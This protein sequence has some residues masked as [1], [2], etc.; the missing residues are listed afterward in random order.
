MGLFVQLN[1]SLSMR[2]FLL[3]VLLIPALTGLVHAQSQALSLR[4]HWEPGK[5]YRQ[6]TSTETTSPSPGKEAPDQQLNV[7]Q[8]TLLQV[9]KDTPDHQRQVGVTFASVRGEIRANGKTLTYDS[10]S[11]ETQNPALRQVF[12]Q[13]VGKKF[14]LVYD[15]QDRFVDVR[16]MMSLSSEAGSITSLSAVADANQ[17]ALLF[18]KSLEMGLP[19]LPVHV[20]DTWTMDETMPFPKAGEVRVQ[21]NGKLAAVESY[22][23]RPHARIVFEGKFGNTAA[24]ADKP[25]SLTEITSD[26]SISGVLYFDLESRIVSLTSYTTKIKLQAPGEVIP[27]EQK[28]TSKVSVQ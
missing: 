23:G 20:G 22:Q 2:H 27:F 7:I 4:L 21:M 10:T 11:P 25:L 14:T 24:R 26:S 19:P 12:G 13:A 5:L 8:T 16:D 15:E 3:P 9:A 1:C 17:V 18:R 28:V 6:E